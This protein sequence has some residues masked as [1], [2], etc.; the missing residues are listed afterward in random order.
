MLI[1]MF[2]HV[3]SMQEVNVVLS[4]CL[5]YFRHFPLPVSDDILL[6]ILSLVHLHHKETL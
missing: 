6:Y 2:L 4:L 5:V 3:Q 1:N